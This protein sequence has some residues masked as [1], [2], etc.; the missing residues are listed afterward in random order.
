M[1]RALRTE[2]VYFTP[3]ILGAL[4]IAT[5]VVVLLS[6]LNRI[7]DAGEGVPAFV[8]C[9]FPIIAG[10]VV[11]FIAQSYRVEEHR[12]RLLLAGPL[13]PR[14][15][16]GVKVLLPVCFVGIGAL[17]SIPIL[18]LAFLIAGR[19]EPAAVPAVAG[20]A[21]QFLSYAQLG[22]LAQ[23]SVAARRQGRSAA[24][25]VGWA[26]FAGSILVLA[27]AQVFQHSLGGNMAV[28]GVVICS[29]VLAA[30]LFVRRTDFTS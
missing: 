17:G 6:V 8:V 11:S 26:V 4:G 15:L 22:P 9:M 12:S 5:F 7:L 14:Q 3:W 16:A 19:F 24:S 13:T 27:V 28:A 20:F 2:L 21:G 30:A 29:M 25:M 18:G 10:M 23:E 1:W